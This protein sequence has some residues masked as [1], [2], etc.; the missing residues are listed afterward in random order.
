MYMLNIGV[1]LLS[2][3]GLEFQLANVK[4]VPMLVGKVIP[5]IAC[6]FMKISIDRKKRSN[7]Q[8]VF[9]KLTELPKMVIIDGNVCVMSIGVKVRIIF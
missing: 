7:K 6:R 4:L 8:N 1:G 5:G 3:L 2:M 9:K